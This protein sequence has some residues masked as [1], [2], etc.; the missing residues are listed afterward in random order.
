MQNKAASDFE[1]SK[2]KKLSSTI[3]PGSTIDTSVMVDVSRT[4]A[5]QGRV[6]VFYILNAQLSCKGSI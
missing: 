1:F 4:R 5:V 6:D 2:M 3:L